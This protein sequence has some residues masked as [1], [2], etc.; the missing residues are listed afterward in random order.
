[1]GFLLYTLKLMTA[2]YDLYYTGH[3]DGER[4]LLGQSGRPLLVVLALN[5]STASRERSDLTATKIERISRAAGWGGFAI[6]N[7]YPLRATQP[8]ELP[9]KADPEL[10]RCNRQHMLAT[11]RRAGVGLSLWAAWGAGI[12]QRPWLWQ[13][14]AQL[15]AAVAP[16]EPC[17]LRYGP[18][19]RD[20][21]PRHPS[22][23]GYGDRLEGF[24]LAGYCE[25]HR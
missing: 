2:L 14:L 24:D 12:S 18:P 15:A 22:R 13:A 5:P 7:L 17:W 10:L 21:H 11:A 8:R 19:T 23:V 6:C 16:L 4:Y 1:M 25:Q 20:G 9:L 3:G